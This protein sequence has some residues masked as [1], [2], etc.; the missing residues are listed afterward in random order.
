MSG[1]NP[2]HPPLLKRAVSIARG[3]RTLS[4]SLSE[5]R[6]KYMNTKMKKILSIALSSIVMA[7]TISWM[8]HPVKESTA[9]GS[10][11][12]QFTVTTDKSE[13]HRGQ[14]VTF[15]TVVKNDSTTVQHGV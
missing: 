11:N 4:S 13:V 8:A 1:S 9:A 2:G 5:R 7:A 10:N 12:L 3:Q 6:W 14:E 15:K